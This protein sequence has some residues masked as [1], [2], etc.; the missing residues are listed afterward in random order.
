MVVE[1]MHRQCVVML[2]AISRAWLS[3]ASRARPNNVGGQ[4]GGPFARQLNL[5]APAYES[6]ATSRDLSRPAV[7]TADYYH[8]DGVHWFRPYDL[9]N[10]FGTLGQTIAAATGYRYICILSPDHADES[11]GRGQRGWGYD[12][13]CIYLGYTNDPAILPSPSTLQLIIAYRIDVPEIGAYDGLQ[14]PWL[15]YN[16]DDATYP[17]YLYLEGHEIKGQTRTGREEELLF[18]SSDLVT[19][20]F[21]GISHATTSENR[22]AA[23][24]GVYRLGVKNWISYG[25]ADA[26]PSP[27]ALGVWTSTDA[28]TFTLDHT[29]NHMFNERIFEINQAQ[30]VTIGGQLYSVCREDA[31]LADGGMYV[32]LAPIDKEG[33][34]MTSSPDSIVRLSTIYQGVYPGPTYLECV[35]GYAED[36]VYHAWASHGFFSDNGLVWGASFENGG[37][38]DEQYLDYYSFI[39]DATMAACAA[40]IGVRATCDRGIVTVQWYDALPNNTYRVYRS[41]AATDTWRFLG[42][43][44]GSSFTDS[45]G[46]GQTWYYKVVTLQNGAERQFRVVC[47]YA[48][49]ALQ[50]VNDHIGRVLAAG[51]DPATIDTAWLTSVVSWLSTHGLINNLMFWTDPA[52]GCRL[53]GSVI[54]SVFD[55][56]T[57]RLPRGGDYTP[58]TGDTAY[59]ATGLNATVPAFTNRTASAFGYYGSGRLN[60]IRRKEQITVVA[61][62]QKSNRNRTTLISFGEVFSL[63]NTAGSPG[64]ASFSVAGLGSRI[65]NALRYPQIKR[66][67]LRLIGPPLN[68]KVT[69][70]IG[71]THSTAHII[72][73]TFDGTTITAYAEGVAGTG[74]TGVLDN[75]ALSGQVG[76]QTEIDL[77]AVGLQVSK[78]S[79]G[80]VF[81]S[82]ETQ[83]SASDLILFDT[84]LNA[85]QIASLT[86]LLRTRIGPS[87]LGRD[88]SGVIC[89]A[90]G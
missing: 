46:M 20:M 7:S 12:A 23:Y 26:A 40:P 16:P 87:E 52:F 34:L 65:T 13:A 54:Q 4:G 41:P 89:G 27:F 47:V 57:T 66:L 9:Q 10:A 19:W 43:V 69:A 38:L 90:T 72:A 11:V 85:A 25:A 80:Y 77:L 49:A 62:Y 39:Y 44:A 18:R 3:G 71:L 30:R 42:D 67:I 8:L 17:F 51:A 35:S 29:I 78:D 37:G 75:S 24:H 36:G 53:S 56:G 2:A 45:P 73:G 68:Y 79:S 81:R 58:F 60:N 82:N 59:D 84:S 48:T 15:V 22:C 14:A 64:S 6:P 76:G 74:Q 5:H 88:A 1:R 70:S 86:T 33:N 63:Q 21:Q 32:S 55:L 31:R 28:L 50:L 61:A 83:F